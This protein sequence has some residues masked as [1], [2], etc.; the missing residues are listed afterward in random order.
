VTAGA[1]PQVGFGARRGRRAI[2]PESRAMLP[3]G[4]RLERGP[5]GL[6]R[7]AMASPD[8]DAIVYLH[9]A[10]VAHYR[11]R[12][13]AHPV[14]WVSRD[15][16]FVGG[17]PGKA[18]RGGVPICFPWFGAK[19]GAPE[20]P[21]HGVARV[22]AWTLGPVTRE[23][24]GALRASLSLE[25]DDFT[26]RLYPHDFVATFTVTVGCRL[27]MELAV[28]NAGADPM[29]YEEALHSYFAVGDARRVAV[30]GLEGA[31]YFDKTDGGARKPGEAAP[32]AIARETDR[33]YAGARGTV[34]IADPVWDRRIVVSKSGSDTT[35]VWNPWIDKA[36]SLADFGDDEWLEMV[37]V[38]SANA[39]DD[40]RTLPPGAT[41][42]L[43]TT[44]DVAPF[45][46]SA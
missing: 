33:V 34:T 14:M 11:P 28:R 42:A 37:C 40:A 46:A 20:A 17:A 45:G 3:E 19:A 2:V 6:E 9:G 10:H 1:P 18:I 44:I 43:A 29:R 15:S 25:S 22:L 8:G 38:E 41:H 30:H 13:A 32:I 36:R 21:S 26:R 16:H 12:G 39:G 4:A 7:L 31:P 35:V 24:D 5:G 27:Q 23:A